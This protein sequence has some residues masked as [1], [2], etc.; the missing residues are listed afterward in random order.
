MLVV[1]NLGL[2]EDLQT[3]KPAAFL[4]SSTK[5]FTLN[6]S[7]DYR[8]MKAAY[9]VSMH[10]EVLGSQ[11]VPTTENIIDVNRTPLLLLKAS[12]AGIP[13]LPYIVTSSVRQIVDGCGFPVV[14]FAVNPFCYDGF[15]T[16]R[17]K[18]ALYRAVRSMSM[19]YKFSVCVQPLRGELRT[20]KSL[21]GRTESED[22][23]RKIARRVYEVF[24]L[25]ICKLHIQ[26]IGSEVYLCGLQP[27]KT[28]EVTATD[29]Q[30]I[31]TEVSR[32][33][34]KGEHPVG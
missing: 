13:T 33:L 12:R 30:L 5:D 1:S 27:L 14:L 31:S 28:E 10:A 15:K 17:N 23:A 3:M 11:V 26:L 34:N 6:V 16:A 8:Y 19:N 21:F 2:A 25:P 18:S 7:I 4:N 20:I 24:N 32:I 9:Y 29:L 22:T